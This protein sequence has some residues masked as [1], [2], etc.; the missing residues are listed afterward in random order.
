MKLRVPVPRV[1]PAHSAAFT[2]WIPHGVLGSVRNDRGTECFTA[3]MNASADR[4]Q[5]RAALCCLVS[6]VA[7][8]RPRDSSVGVFFPRRLLPIEPLTPLSPLPLPRNVGTPSRS[9]SFCS[10]ELIAFP[11]EEAAEVAVTTFS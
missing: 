6:R 11:R 4:S 7:S 8:R 3:P 5:T 10:Y 9:F 2:A 1:F